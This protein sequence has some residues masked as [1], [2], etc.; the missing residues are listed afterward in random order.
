MRSAGL[1]RER[2]DCRERV[3]RKGG[4]GCSDLKRRR[5]RWRVGQREEHDCLFVAPERSGMP[6]K[7]SVLTR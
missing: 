4:M 7:H 6:L 3:C 5:W 1:G 2:A